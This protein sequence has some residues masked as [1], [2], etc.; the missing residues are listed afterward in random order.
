[1]LWHI[2]QC[3]FVAHGQ[4]IHRVVYLKPYWPHI[5]SAIRSFHFVWL[6]WLFL[7]L[8][9]PLYLFVCAF[10]CVL[11][12]IHMQESISLAVWYRPRRTIHNFLKSSKLEL[13]I[14]RLHLLYDDLVHRKWWSC[15]DTHSRNRVVDCNFSVNLFYVSFLLH[16]LRSAHSSSSNNSSTSTINHMWSRR[17]NQMIVGYAKSLSFARCHSTPTELLLFARYNI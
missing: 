11:L 3:F 12:R 8:F 13:Y 10:D 5:E 9:F 15:K 17:W 1:M 2:N 6:V 4:W 16:A 14:R 7:S